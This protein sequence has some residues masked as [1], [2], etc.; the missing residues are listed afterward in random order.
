MGDL[1]TYDVLREPRGKTYAELLDAARRECNE[2]ILIT[3]ERMGFSDN[4]MRVLAA[5]REDQAIAPVKVS[6]WPGTVV[7]GG[8]A[9]Q[10]RVRV[11]DR[12]IEVL[13]REAARLYRWQQPK[14]PQD[15]CFFAAD[16][17]CWLAT[18]AHER[19]AF[20]SLSPAEAEK[21]RQEVPELVLAER[22]DKSSAD[23]VK[24]DVS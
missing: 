24:S 9:T 19:D 18:I 6:E 1:K 12:S 22:E 16:G 20:M 10:Y 14:L 4:L 17:R 3:H 23:G 11:S 15:P 5:L 13:K 2:F 7:I 8:E 21:V